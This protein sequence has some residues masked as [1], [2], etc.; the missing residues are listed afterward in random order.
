MADEEPK[1][2]QPPRSLH[3]RLYPYMDELVQYAIHHLD[4]P[5][6]NRD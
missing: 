6:T 1:G 2:E 3:H 5:D 4:R